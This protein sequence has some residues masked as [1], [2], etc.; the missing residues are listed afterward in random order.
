MLITGDQNVQTAQQAAAGAVSTA[1]TL[2]DHAQRWVDATDRLAGVFR[3]SLVL[4][5][6]GTDADRDTITDALKKIADDAAGARRIL[7]SE[8]EQL[9]IASAAT[10]MVASERTH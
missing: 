9:L 4:C 2:L 7:A 5:R 3:E 10:A 6:C 8:R 1:L